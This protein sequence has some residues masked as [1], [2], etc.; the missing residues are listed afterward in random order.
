MKKIEDLLR[1]EATAILDEAAP[2]IERLE[3]YRRDGADSTRRR[4][5]ALYRHVVRAVA[6]CDLDG[7]AAHAARVARARFEQGFDV[8]EV[9][10]AFA[11]L[12]EAIERRAAVLPPEER[13]AVSASLAHARNELW[14]TFTALASDRARL[15][16]GPR[17]PRT[18]RAEELVYPV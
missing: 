4:V 9:R 6:A 17:S 3:H 13:R 10:S 14:R 18:R 2:T 8:S 5:E 16:F 1:D 7:L 12:E 11:A 15:R